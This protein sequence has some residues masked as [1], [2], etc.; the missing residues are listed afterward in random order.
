M[1]NPTKN[2]MYKALLDK[3]ISFEGVFIVGVK[4]TGIFCRPTC[5]ARKPKRE[6]VE[7]FKNTEDALLR[8]YR[9]CKVCSPMTPIGESPE[10]LKPL[11]KK[12]ENS[13][14]YKLKDWEIRN[15][16]IDPNRVRRWFK[17]NHNMTF[18]CFLRSLRIG[19][20]HGRLVDGKKV[21]EVALGSGHDSLSGFN[22][23]Y[24]KLLN[25]SPSKAK[26][27]LT[28]STYKLLTPLGPMMAAS[29]D[30][31]ICLLEFVDRRMLE[32]ELV[33]LKRIF[34]SEL[35]IHES[36]HIKKLSKELKEYFAG[37]RKKFE[38]PLVYPGTDFQKKV[39]KGLQKIAYGKTTTY[40][41]QAKGLKCEKSVRAVANANGANR[42]S[43]IIPCH[44]V[45]G[46]DGS[47]TGYG[48]GIWRK[49]KLLELECS[50]S[51]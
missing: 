22:D 1:N 46:S 47:L 11:L 10:W 49:Q 42:I 12:I 48:G 41:D 14:E 44:R 19:A 32:K 37:K 16:G 13:K 26:D 7:F 51:N 28:I 24:K 30:E 36:R 29:V 39:W 43:I 40:K 20:S 35:I 45:I 21:I 23:S 3:D 4:T 18:Q 27:I 34:K 15:L 25:S 9:P 33:D 31:G 38:V 5:S 8:G 50:N 2:R 6:N 17:K